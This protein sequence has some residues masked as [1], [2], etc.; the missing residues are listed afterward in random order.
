MKPA[1]GHRSAARRRTR[2]TSCAAR[3]LVAYLD[4]QRAVTGALPTDRTIVIE[5]F[6]DEL[7][8]W[9]VVLLTP[10]G[11]RVHAPWSMVDRGARCAS[12]TASRSSRSGPTTGSPCACPRAP[13]ATARRSRRPS[14]P[15][16]TRSRTAL[17]AELGGSALFAARFRENAARALLL[18]RRR[19]G[20]RTPL[21]MQ[22]QRS[23]DLLAVASQLR[24]VPDH[25]RDLP[26]GPA[27]RLRHAGAARAARR[28]P[29]PADPRGQRRDRDPPRRSR[30]R[31]CSTTSARSCTRA[32]RR[33]PSAGRR[34]WR[35]TASC[36]PSCSAA[37][38]CA[39]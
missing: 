6:R 12:A 35:S 13:R 14:S 19:P 34:R 25:P 29:R 11:G 26:R 36:S 9:R 18:P 27:R 21:W 37:R 30:A 7:G 32:T 24:L 31:C 20:Q 22:R 33:S 2:S 38:S 23:A 10:F 16:P 1:A 3:N 17:M 15:I 5:R 28:H 8:D 4:E 39:S